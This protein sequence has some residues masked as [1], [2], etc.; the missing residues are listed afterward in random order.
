[1]SK[2]TQVPILHIILSSSI[3][4]KPLFFKFYLCIFGCAGYLLLPGLS[5]AVASGGHPL[6]AMHR[7]LTAVASPGAEHTGSRHTGSRRMGSEVV[8]PGPRY[9]S[10]RGL[11]RDQG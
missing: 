6:V 10:A 9:S 2:K 8:A 3:T 1:M 5:L 4:M 11:F 7:L